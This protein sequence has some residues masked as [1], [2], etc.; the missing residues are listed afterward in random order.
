MVIVTSGDEEGYGPVSQEP[1][2]KGK[3]SQSSIATK[4]ERQTVFEI[5]MELSK[6]SD[7]ELIGCFNL[8]NEFFV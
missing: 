2:P 8:S 1:L 5:E 7:V 4:I 6:S 3:S